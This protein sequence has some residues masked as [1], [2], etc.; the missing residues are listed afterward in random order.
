[1]G[2]DALGLNERPG[3][4]VMSPTKD[5]LRKTLHKLQRWR[6]VKKGDRKTEH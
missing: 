6:I 2:T 5:V 4:L 3:L 1:M